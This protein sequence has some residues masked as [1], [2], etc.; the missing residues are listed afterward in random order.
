[1]PGDPRTPKGEY[2]KVHIPGAMLFDLEEISDRSSNLPHMLASPDAFAQAVSALGVSNTDR[3]VIYDHVGLLSAAR[4]WWNFRIMGHDAV[5][6]LDGGLPRWTG[7]GRPVC[8]GPQNEVAPGA[9]TARFR[10]RLLR[11]LNLV[12]DAL[13]AG[14]QVLDARSAG[15]FSGAEPEPRPGLPSG[16]MPGARNLPHSTIIADGALLPPDELDA[17]FRTAGVDLWLW[18][19]RRDLGLGPGETWPLGH[20]D[21]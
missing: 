7:E 2:E 15:R 11:D 1:M 16:H 9:F 13:A 20:A 18:R 14:A 19:Q 5:W 6:V 21:L 3:V 4:V 12:K 10:P 8:N 17:R